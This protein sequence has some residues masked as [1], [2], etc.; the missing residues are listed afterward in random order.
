[1][2]RAQR[3]G[4]GWVGLGRV[5]SGWVRLGQVGTAAVAAMAITIAAQTPQPAAPKKV[6]VV[7]A[8]R[9]IDGQGGAPMANP[10]VVVE[11]D[12]IT[13]VGAGLPVPAGA[14]V[15]DLGGATLLP[16]LIDCHTHLTGQ[17]GENYY[18]DM[19]RKS[20]I[21]GAM[22]AHVYARRTLEAG[23]TAVRD[24]GAGELVDVAMER[25]QPRRDGRSA[26]AGGHAR[27]ERDGRARR[28]VRVFP[29]PATRF[30][31]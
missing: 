11:D 2:T 25:D 20:P 8:A 10:V 5:G 7:K 17:P 16:G 29:V 30:R 26:H 31:I 18:D 4:S 21:D 15:I 6:T 28:H 1:M 27:G 23:F 9:L 13:R 19:F 22:V 24:V 14:E 3:V 12:R